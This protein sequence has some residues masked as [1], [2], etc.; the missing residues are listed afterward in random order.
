MSPFVIPL[1]VFAMVVVIVAIA[2]LASIRETELEIH[3]K[4]YAAE[5]EHQRKI[6]E[7]QSQLERINQGK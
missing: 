7:L 6:R 1:A 4:L 2:H 5:M 3:R